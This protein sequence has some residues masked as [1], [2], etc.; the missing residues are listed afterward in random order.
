MGTAAPVFEMVSNLGQ[1]RIDGAEKVESGVCCWYAWERT[2]LSDALWHPGQHLQSLKWDRA[3]SI[4]ALVLVLHLEDLGE[5]FRTSD[6][7]KSLLADV[8]DNN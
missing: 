6:G 2:Q 4:G 3:S 1:T 8:E 7:L 5:T